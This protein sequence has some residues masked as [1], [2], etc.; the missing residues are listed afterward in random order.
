[1]K[2]CY[3][4]TGNPGNRQDSRRKSVLKAVTMEAG[5][6]LFVSTSE[7]Q[8]CKRRI[9]DEYLTTQSGRILFDISQNLWTTFSD[10]C[11]CP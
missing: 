8:E 4:G 7:R 10:F 2:S 3:R 9:Y 11:V 6:E 5:E 1:M